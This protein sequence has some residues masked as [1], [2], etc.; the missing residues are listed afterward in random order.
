MAASVRMSKLKETVQVKKKSF[1]S[2]THCMCVCVKTKRTIAGNVFSQSGTEI[3]RTYPIKKHLWNII[4]VLNAYSI[5]F[6]PISELAGRR[7]VAC[8]CNETV[9]R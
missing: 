3:M 5:C 4:K 8:S 9:K 1:T 7:K 2:T 6:T